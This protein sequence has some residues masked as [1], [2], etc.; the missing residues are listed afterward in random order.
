M[1]PPSSKLPNGA[2]GSR[3]PGTTSATVPKT[4]RP[5]SM[6]GNPVAKKTATPTVAGASRKELESS[7]PPAHAATKAPSSSATLRD[8]IAKAKAAKRA[9]ASSSGLPQVDGSAEYEFDLSADP[10]NAR[11]KDN[12]GLLLKRID[13]ARADGRLNIAAMGLKTIPGEVLR[14]YDA[15]E[16]AK[17]KINWNE[18]VD[19]TRLIAADNEIETIADEIF[20]DLDAESAAMDDD[21][22]SA[23][24]LQ[25]R[26][27]DML[28][29]HG[30]MLTAI[31]VGLKRLERLTVVNLVRKKLSP[32]P[33]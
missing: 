24:G 6:Y 7:Y 5:T 33:G 27:L 2:G 26:G 4:A 8:Q 22:D 9:V 32:F 15:D 28:D 13:A 25:F 19:L 1:K 29:L 14:M 17:S 21:D 30:N 12:N 23:K 11:P 10:F 3:L 16:M 31:P 20:P 18:T